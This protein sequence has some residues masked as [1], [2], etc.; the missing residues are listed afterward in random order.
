MY[1]IKRILVA[2]D[3]SPIDQSLIR[4]AYRLSTVQQIEKIYFVSVVKNLD[5]PEEI[6]AAYPELLAPMDESLKKQIHDTIGK[7]VGEKLS[8]PFDIDIIEGDTTKQVLR[9]AKIKGVDLILLGKKSTSDGSGINGS[10]IARLS[11]CH[12]AFIPEKMPEEHIHL[13]V[14]VD[15]SDPS[16]LAVEL[17]LKIAHA[18][19]HARVSCMH[20]YHVPSGYHVSGKSRSEFSEI[21]KKTSEKLYRQFIDTID[22]QGLEVPCAMVLGDLD[23]VPELVN[24]HAA[25]HSNSG[26]VIGSKGKT[27]AASLLLGSTT[28]RFIDIGLDHPLVVAKPKN[29]IM[30]VFDAIMK[31]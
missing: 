17:A 9:W 23:K 24:E 31:S 6:S 7:T 20:V 15:F 30:D 26:V 16:K 1:D 8:T 25:K 19:T 22:T 5:L 4:Y 11:P 21:M 27:K 12:V 13:L 28:E 29:E 18:N 3:L 10:K 2:V 14:P